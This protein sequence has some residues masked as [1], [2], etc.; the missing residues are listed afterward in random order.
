MIRTAGLLA[1]AMVAEM[2]YR[3]VEREEKRKGGEEKT[4]V[5]S[6]G[7]PPACGPLVHSCVARKF[8]KIAFL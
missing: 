1:S 5:R 3:G 7:E 2:R 8:G 4:K 6:R